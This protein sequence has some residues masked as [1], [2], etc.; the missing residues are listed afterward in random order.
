MI[1][2]LGRYTAKADEDICFVRA[3]GEPE[4]VMY[5]APMADTL[6]IITAA[7]LALHPDVHAE[8][9]DSRWVSHEVI[10]TPERQG[11]QPVF[12]VLPW[13]VDETGRRVPAKAITINWSG[14]YYHGD[15][16]IAQARAYAVAILLTCHLAEEEYR[17]NA[18]NAEA[19]LK[20]E[21]P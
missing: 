13:G 14:G 21:R 7:L 20:G 9:G 2:K 8:P 5:A 17:K 12:S 4:P 10:T 18:K 11:W 15:D 1:R 6:Q 3:D 19:V 16:A